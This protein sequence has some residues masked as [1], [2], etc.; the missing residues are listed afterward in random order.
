MRTPWAPRRG[1]TEDT[2][3]GLQ[4]G[5]DYSSAWSKNATAILATFFV[6]QSLHEKALICSFP[7]QKALVIMGTG[8]CVRR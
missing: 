7:V 6:P 8:A 2:A 1:R 5:C 3:C 4:R